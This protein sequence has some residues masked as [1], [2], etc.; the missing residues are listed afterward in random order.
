MQITRKLKYNDRTE[1][2]G[3][4][5]TQQKTLAVLEAM[6]SAM[7][8]SYNKKYILNKGASV[9]NTASAILTKLNLG[10]HTPFTKVL[11]IRG[12]G[13]KASVLE[14]GNK[15]LRE[16]FGYKRY[17]SIRVGHSFNLYKSI[18]EYIGIKVIKK[19]RK[20]LVY[21]PDKSKVMSYINSIYILRPPSVYTGRG[22]R[23]KGHRHVRKLGKKDLK[24]GKT[25]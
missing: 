22:I 10:T 11:I 19:D 8:F 2:F 4:T 3:N 16:D 5:T 1:N 23:K 17:L 13:Y 15:S 21:G 25:F 6:Q 12:I 24:K 18:P 14:N 20:L 9:T 7:M